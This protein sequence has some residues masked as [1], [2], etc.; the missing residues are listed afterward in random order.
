MCLIAG[1]ATI[2]AEGENMIIMING[3]PGTGKTTLS[4]IIEEKYGYSYVSDW[5]IFAENKITINPKESKTSIS[6]KYSNLIVQHIKNNQKANIVLDL[7]YSIS[8]KDFVKHDLASILKCYYLGFSSLPN[9]TLFDLFRKSSANNDLSDAELKN[10]IEFYK[11]ASLKYKQQCEKY[12]LEFI[13]V[14]KD[15]KLI[16]DEIL[17]KISK[18]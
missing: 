1:F 7:E 17:S 8:P 4:K 3:L 11:L 2:I 15:R 14:C 9:K 6:K 16:F 12:G 13:D 10:R 18:E 5:N